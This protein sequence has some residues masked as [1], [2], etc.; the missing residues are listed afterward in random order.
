MAFDAK[1]CPDAI[2]NPTRSVLLNDENYLYRLREHPEKDD[3]DYV[4]VLRDPDGAHDACELSDT[5]YF[6]PG[7]GA[8][9]RIAGYHEHRKGFELFMVGGEGAKCLIR[10][11]GRQ[12]WAYPGDMIFLPPATPHSFLWYGNPLR[13][14][15]M[16]SGMRMNPGGNAN[17]LILEFHPDAHDDPEFEAVYQSHSDYIAHDHPTR[18]ADADDI[19]EVIRLGAGAA[20]FELNGVRMLQKVTRAQWWGQREVWQFRLPEGFTITCPHSN[21]REQILMVYA[22]QVR[23]RIRGVAEFVAKQWDYVDI[24]AWLDAELTVL[25][26]EAVVFDMNCQGYLYSALEEIAMRAEGEPRLLAD[27]AALRSILLKNDVRLFGV[28]K[29]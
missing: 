17:W 6:T 8:L 15:E 23:V 12:T 4:S 18:F 10:V 21:D 25:S 9:P 13:W 28:P 19:P 2:Y 7:Q 16:F 5:F 20:A 27:E 29:N 22:G 1:Y 3:P 24:P 11:R 26:D 14:R